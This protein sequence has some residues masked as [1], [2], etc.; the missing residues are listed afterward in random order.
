MRTHQCE[1]SNSSA[2]VRTGNGK[3]AKDIVI[4]GHADLFLAPID[5]PTQ[6]AP[7]TLNIKV[8]DDGFPEGFNEIG[9]GDGLKKF[10]EESSDRRC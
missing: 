2:T 10:E 8:N 1:N 9:S 7:G 5:W 6:L 4:P 3:F